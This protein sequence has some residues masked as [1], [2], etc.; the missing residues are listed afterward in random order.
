MSASADMIYY[1]GLSNKKPSDKYTPKIPQEK[2]ETVKYRRYPYSHHKLGSKPKYS[3]KILDE[4][5]ASALEFINSHPTLDNKQLN[6]IESKIK[7]YND[8]KKL[9]YL[10]SN[11][12]SFKPKTRKITF[13]PGT[14][15]GG[16]KQS[17]KN[18]KSRGS[19]RNRH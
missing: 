17:R 2:V 7:E 15:A 12:E 14:K 16:K 1:Y 18:K 6:Y 3:V 4:K 10:E 8:K 5:I 13:A 19:R 9:M 11:E